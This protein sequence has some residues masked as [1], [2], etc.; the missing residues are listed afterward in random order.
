MHVAF[1]LFFGHISRTQQW[2]HTFGHKAKENVSGKE[3]VKSKNGSL[4]PRDK[5]RL[6]K[7][8]VLHL[9][10]N[11]LQCRH[12]K[13]IKVHVTRVGTTYE[14]THDRIILNIVNPPTLSL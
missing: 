12:V 10:I 3:L 11:E 8:R 2:K 6:L 5:H 14:R 4:F 1:F 13:V 9:M 7:N